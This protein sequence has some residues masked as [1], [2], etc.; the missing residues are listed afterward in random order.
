MTP[1]DQIKY[2]QGQCDDAKKQTEKVK[3]MLM[4][5]IEK[6]QDEADAKDKRIADLSNRMKV[7]RA[8]VLDAYTKLQEASHD[9]R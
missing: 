8:E 5:V 6:M 9:A 3:R 1:E 7:L 4:R 2:W